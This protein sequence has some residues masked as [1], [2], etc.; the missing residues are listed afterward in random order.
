MII[1]SFAHGKFQT[2]GLCVIWFYFLE[3][4]GQA[5]IVRLGKLVGPRDA[6]RFTYRACRRFLAKKGE[7]VE[8]SVVD[9]VG[10][11]FSHKTM[12]MG[13]LDEEV[14]EEIPQQPLFPSPYWIRKIVQEGVITAGDRQ[15]LR[16]AV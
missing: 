15:L 8:A 7:G 16:N 2:C 5:A 11:L 9:A 10:G 14:M 12:T 6:R 13:T 1:Y 3:K 4:V